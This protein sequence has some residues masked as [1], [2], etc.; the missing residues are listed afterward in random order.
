[1]ELASERNGRAKVGLDDP[2]PCRSGE[3]YSKCHGA[4]KGFLPD[5]T[6]GNFARRGVKMEEEGRSCLV[7]DKKIANPKRM[8]NSDAFQKEILI[9]DYSEATKEDDFNR[10]LKGVMCGLIAQVVAF[11][12]QTGTPIPITMSCPHQ[13]PQVI[14]AFG[15]F[16]YR[17]GDRQMHLEFCY[18]CSDTFVRFYRTQWVPRKD[19]S[20]SDFTAEEIAVLQQIRDYIL[21]NWD[22]QDYNPWSCRGE[23]SR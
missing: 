22:A 17:G 2:C 13:G 5:K 1:M 12:E 3:K 14:S 19:R 23:G 11:N 7:R 6:R 15:P 9:K 18:K 10:M 21:K 16:P 4:G 8:L 20:E